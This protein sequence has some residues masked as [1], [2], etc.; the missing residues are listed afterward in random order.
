VDSLKRKGVL[1][2][3][4]QSPAGAELSV[5][6]VHLQAGRRNGALRSRQLEQLLAALE[7]ECR[8]VVLMGD[9]NFYAGVAEDQQSAHRLGSAGFA[10]AALALGRCEATFVASNPYVPRWHRPERFDRV[11]LR[12]AGGVALR[13][14][15]TEVVR[16]ERPLSDHHPLR[17][18][19]RVSA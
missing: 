5:A 17:A 2:A 10:D 19:V 15:E 11:Y 12:D 9:F 16:T 7:S 14:L 4:A 13:P 18:R 1:R 6:V 8:P 3:R